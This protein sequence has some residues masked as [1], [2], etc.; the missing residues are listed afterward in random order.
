MK[1]R[2]GDDVFVLA[3]QVPRRAAHVEEVLPGATR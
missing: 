3:G 2:K 1:I